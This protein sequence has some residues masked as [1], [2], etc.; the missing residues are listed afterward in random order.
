MKKKPIVTILAAGALALVVFGCKPDLSLSRASVS[1]DDNQQ[2]ASFILENRG[3]AS[4]SSFDVE[5]LLV[6]GSVNLPGITHTIPIAGLAAGEKLEFRNLSLRYLLEPGNECLSRITEAIISIDPRNVIAEAN[7]NNNRQ[8][9]KIPAIQVPCEGMVRFENLASGIEY[10]PISHIASDGVRFA[11]RALPDE[12]A[13][14]AALQGLSLGHGQLLWLNH[15]WLEPKLC[16]PFHYISFDAGYYGGDIYLEVNGDTG[17]SPYPDISAIDGITIGGVAVEVSGEGDNP[18]IWSFSG[19]INS[20][21]V[22]GH[23]LAIDNMIFWR[24]QK[25][26]L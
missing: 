18:G 13:Y 22:G 9:V 8:A 1:W 20:F 14:A 15:V 3:G 16:T 17:A 26:L 24:Q 11:I 12:G 19:P 10:T 4:A 21:K 2:A 25:R 5:I 6:E 23:S 7:E